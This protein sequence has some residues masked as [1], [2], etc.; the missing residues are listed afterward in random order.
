MSVEIVKWVGNAAALPDAT[1]IALKLGM[2]GYGFLLFF[3][4]S[5]LWLSAGV[6]THDW[7]RLWCFRPHSPRAA[8]SADYLLS[9]RHDYTPH[10]NEGFAI[11]EY[12]LHLHVSEQLAKLF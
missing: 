6:I 12:A 2:E 1:I 9:F 7:G 3:I 8:C 10:Q 4:A 11:R 5:V